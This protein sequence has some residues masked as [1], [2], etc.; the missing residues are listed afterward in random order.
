MS[1]KSAPLHA[2]APSVTLRYES[3]IATY[4]RTRNEVSAAGWCGLGWK[5]D[6]PSVFVSHN[7]TV[8]MS[9]DRWFF[10]DGYGN[11]SEIVRVLP[12]TPTQEKFYFKSNPLQRV[13]VID[14]SPGQGELRR[15]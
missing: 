1:T 10:D 9:D 7:N 4:T 14:N 8:D 15:I 2:L 12:G 5:F 13:T 11:I 6:L 3:D